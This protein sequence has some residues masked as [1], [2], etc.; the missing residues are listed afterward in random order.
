MRKILL[1]IIAL[2]WFL[3]SQGQELVVNFTYDEVCL[4]GIT[5]FTSLC[6][7]SD[8]ATHPRDSIVSLAWDLKG[9]GKFNDC[10]LAIKP[11]KHPQKISKPV[12]I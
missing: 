12:F 9:D 1:A 10:P 8:T 4:G 5:H 7:I 11:K 2:T 6:Y 3:P